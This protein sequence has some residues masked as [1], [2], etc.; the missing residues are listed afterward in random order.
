LEE[1][2]EGPSRIAKT[3][4]IGEGSDEAGAHLEKEK[5][6]TWAAVPIHEGWSKALRLVPAEGLEPLESRFEETEDLLPIGEVLPAVGVTR[7]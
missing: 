3:L 6:R 5:A 4:T 1:G 7:R 2:E